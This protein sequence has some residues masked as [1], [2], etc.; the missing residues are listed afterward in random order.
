MFHLHPKCFLSASLK[1]IQFNNNFDVQVRQDPN[2]SSFW[3]V[4][5]CR[6]CSFTGDV[7]YFTG[8]VM[9]KFICIFEVILTCNCKIRKD[10]L[11]RFVN[12]HRLLVNRVKMCFFAVFIRYSTDCDR[13]K[14]ACFVV[15][16]VLCVQ[17]FLFVLSCC[18]TVG[19]SSFTNSDQLI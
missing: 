16:F 9:S 10:S 6:W 12:L 13:S 14:S 5:W 3:F 4:F 15:S 8:D 19:S 18:E 11:N 1:L 17:L 2:P 7:M